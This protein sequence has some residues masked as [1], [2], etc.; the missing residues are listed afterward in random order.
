M[1]RDEALQ[2]V[3]TSGFRTSVYVYWLFARRPVDIGN[4]LTMAAYFIWRVTT[5]AAA[6]TRAFVREGPRGSRML[7]CISIYVYF[8]L[9]QGLCISDIYTYTRHHRPYVL[10]WS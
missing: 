3:L 4:R 6:G 8:V 10:A 9:N 7:P 5:D 2:R 1:G